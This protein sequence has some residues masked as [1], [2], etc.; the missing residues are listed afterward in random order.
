MEKALEK[1]EN[2]LSNLPVQLPDNSIN[3]KS[4]KATKEFS[5]K[6]QLRMLAFTV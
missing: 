6:L 5:T 1:N 4:E 2:Y 3:Q